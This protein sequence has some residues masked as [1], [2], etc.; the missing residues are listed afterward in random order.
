MLVLMLNVY[1]N[2][3]YLFFQRRQGIFG[4]I[5]QPQYGLILGR[6]RIIKL[7]PLIHQHQLW[8]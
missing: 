8:F 1:I 3:N 4:R 7:I 6:P 2:Y 5:H